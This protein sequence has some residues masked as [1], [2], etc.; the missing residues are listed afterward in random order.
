MKLIDIKNKFNRL[1][2]D[3]LL[4]KFFFDYNYYYDY[5]YFNRLNNRFNRL[6]FNDCPS[7]FLL[8]YF[9]L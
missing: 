6:Y 5:D 1:I 8:Q 4:V 3:F 2:I 9:L 7:L